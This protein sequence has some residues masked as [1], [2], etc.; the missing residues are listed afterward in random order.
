MPFF[1]PLAVWLFLRF[2]YRTSSFT[3][4]EYLERRFDRG[5]RVWGAIVFLVAR[6][7]YLAVVFYSAASIF[8]TLLGWRPWIT[9]VGVGLFHRL[10]LLP[11]WDEGD[12]ADGCGAECESSFPRLSSS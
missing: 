4:Y 12:R 5:V 7:L 3:A 1:T 11:G 6:L 9:V 10:L 2:F 8:E